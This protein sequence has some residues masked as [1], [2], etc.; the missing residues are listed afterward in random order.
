MVTDEMRLIKK[1]QIDSKVVIASA[2]NKWQLEKQKTDVMSALSENDEGGM[3]MVM[4]EYIEEEDQQEMLESIF[5]K[6]A[7]NALR[8][9]SSTNSLA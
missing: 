3:M 6:E 4:P 2:S 9:S 7:P 5:D 1:N 8:E